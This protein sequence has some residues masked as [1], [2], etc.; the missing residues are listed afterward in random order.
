RLTLQSKCRETSSHSKYFNDLGLMMFLELNLTDVQK[1]ISAFLVQISTGK[2]SELASEL[3][4]KKDPVQFYIILQ[5]LK[6]TFLKKDL[7]S[8]EFIKAYLAKTKAALLRRLAPSV[9]PPCFALMIRL[10]VQLLN[11]LSRDCAYKDLSKICPEII[12]ILRSCKKKDPRT[13][14]DAMPTLQA[15]MFRQTPSVRNCVIDL[16]KAENCYPF[17]FDM[18]LVQA[19]KSSLSP[20]LVLDHD[21]AAKK[22]TNGWIKLF[23]NFQVHSISVMI[24][25]PT[26]ADHRQHNT[27]P[28]KDINDSLWLNQIEMLRDLSHKHII[29]LFAYNTR[30]MPQFYVM[31]DYKHEGN[32]NFQEYLVHLSINKTYLPEATLLNY[33]FQA[34]SALEYCHSKGVV[35]R[36]ITAASFV[37]SGSETV[38]L[39]GFHLS[40][41]LKPTENEKVL[42]NNNICLKS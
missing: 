16:F 4:G 41:F 28:L 3:Q 8:L 5:L 7:Q 36:N 34:A 40:F 6:T 33:L 22:F 39:S 27:T 20:V 17:S 18:H 10:L 32:D 24:H 26:E 35:H 11:C 12:Q 19:V 30:H 13:Y 31:E 38:K 2:P 23:G 21:T 25:V 29:T 15:L 1:S 14:D 9:P 37:V 42:G